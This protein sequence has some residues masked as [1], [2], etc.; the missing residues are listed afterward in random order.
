MEP[1]AQPGREGALCTP[2]SLRYLLPLGECSTSLPA[3]SSQE[4][5]VGLLLKGP[6]PR[7]ATQSAS[8]GDFEVE[9]KESAQ[10]L[11]AAKLG[12]RE[13]RADRGPQPRLAGKAEWGPEVA[14]RQTASPH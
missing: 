4:V 3:T 2:F 9:V 11:L 10:L 1:C 8:P 7:P 6:L 13:P 14:Q 5:L 12:R